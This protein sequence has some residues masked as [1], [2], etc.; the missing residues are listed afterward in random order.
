V[1]L[2]KLGLHIYIA[3]STV[4][5]FLAGWILLA[6]SGKPAT[7]SAAAQGTNSAITTQY[8]VQAV[9]TLAPIPSLDQLAGGATAVLAPQPLPQIPSIGF[10]PRIRTSGS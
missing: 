4:M 3:I 9:P 10:A 7:Y 5:G 1:K 8:A 2:V 6:H